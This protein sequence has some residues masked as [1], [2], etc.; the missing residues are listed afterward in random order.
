MSPFQI[1]VIDDLLSPYINAT[2]VI[3]NGNN[4]ERTRIIYNK[5]ILVRAWGYVGGVMGLFV[6]SVIYV[7]VRKIEI[8]WKVVILENL[9]MVLL[10][11]LYEL[12][13]FNT[14]IYV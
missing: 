3:I 10:L 4:A 1:D 14:I 5:S 9:A 12:M 11:A 6:L 8:R 2:T 7:K 13:F